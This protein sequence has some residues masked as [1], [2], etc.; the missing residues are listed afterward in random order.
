M[1]TPSWLQSV[2]HK[3]GNK[4]SGT[5]KA[6]EWCI[7]TAVYLPVTLISFWGTGTIHRLSSDAI[8]LRAV[9][10]HTVDLVCAVS[11]ACLHTMMLDRRNTYI[12]Y[13]KSWSSGMKDLHPSGNHTINGHMAFHIYNFL[14]LFGPPRSWRCFLFEQGLIG[15]LQRLTHNHKHGKLEASMTMYFL[16]GAQLCQWI[17]HLDCPAILKECKILFDKAFEDVAG[18]DDNPANSAYIST[19]AML[20][21]FVKSHRIALHAWC[22]V[23]QIM[24]CWSSSHVGNSLVMFRDYQG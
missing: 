17:N 8:Y 24:Y 12:R 6:D 14:W 4:F 1:V 22:S 10:H 9:L 19:P 15:H 7:M 16:E 23:N 20:C 3:F 2:L 13:L 21:C 18:E 5:L 11:I